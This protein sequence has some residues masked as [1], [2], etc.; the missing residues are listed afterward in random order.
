[1]GDVGAEM[2]VLVWDNG[3]PLLPV[4]RDLRRGALVLVAGAAM[5][6]LGGFTVLPAS[7]VLDAAV[8][9]KTLALLTVS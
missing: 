1:M 8:S 3:P 7:L 6:V 4:S 2:M 5:V 9:D